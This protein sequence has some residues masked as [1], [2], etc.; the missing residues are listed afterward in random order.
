MGA[1][2]DRFANKFYVKVEESAANT[3]TFQEI[4]T[5]VDVFSKK[6]WVLHRLE[7]YISIGELNKLDSSADKYSAALCSS[8]KIGALDLSD[9]SVVDLFEIAYREKSAVGYDYHIM[10]IIRDFN[11]M[12]GGG[13]IISPRPLFLGLKGLGATAAGA[14]SCRGYFTSMDL[15]AD[16]YLELVDFYRIVQ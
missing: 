14:I 5:S 10:P 6:A 1:K 11:N 12:P 8:N 13:L 15:S 3:L 16:E 4:N 7:Y 2:T 9:P